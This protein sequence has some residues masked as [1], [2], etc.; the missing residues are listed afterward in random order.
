MGNIG[1]G[2]CGWKLS[3]KDAKRER[4]RERECACAVRGP[5]NVWG[6]HRRT[7]KADVIKFDKDAIG[8]GVEQLKV[9][10]K[11]SS[12][13]ACTLDSQTWKFREWMQVL[14]W[15]TFHYQRSIDLQSI[16]GSDSIAFF[17]PESSPESTSEHTAETNFEKDSVNFMFQRDSQY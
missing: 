11:S 16:L 12:I 7:H 3:V 1:M 8:R 15:A 14:G 13:L 4:E 2:S 17:A 9:D 6:T 10:L 5:W